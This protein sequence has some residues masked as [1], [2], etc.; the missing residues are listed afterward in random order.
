MKRSDWLKENGNAG[1]SLEVWN[2]FRFF[3][4][5]LFF[6]LGWFLSAQVFAKSMNYDSRIVGLSKTIGNFTFYS[7]FVYLAACIKYIFYEAFQPYIFASFIPMIACTGV[8]LLFVLVWG[9]IRGMNS[10]AKTLHGTARIAVK[11]DLK[12]NGLLPKEPGI[13]LGQLKN[14]KTIA[15]KESDTV[16]R[17]E[18]KKISQFIATSGKVNVLLLAPTGSAK[19]VG[20][21]IPSLLTYKGSV[22][23]FDPKGENY[24][25]TAGWRGTFSRILKFSPTSRFTVRFN[26]VMA[27]RDG[28]EYAFRDANLIAD[29]IFAPA[30]KSGS[31]ETEQYF[32]NSAK[33]MVTT[34]IMH[35]RFADDINDEDRSLSGVLKFLTQTG[36]EDL[37]NN[38]G[39]EEGGNV[40]KQFLAMIK[41]KH[42]YR[43]QNP[44]GTFKKVEAKN[45]HEK[46]TGGATRAIRM[47]PKEKSSTYSTVFSKLQLFDDP[48]IAYATSGNDFEIEDF[49]TSEE[50]ISLYLAIPYS[51]IERIAPI[52]RILITFMLKKFSEGET[53]HGSVRLKHHLNFIL[54]EF[55]VLGHFPIIAQNMGVLRGY[56][57]NFLIVCQALSQLIDVYGKNH[58]FLDHCVVQVV[59]AP[60][61]T[62]DAEE[63]SKAIGNRTFSEMKISSSGKRFGKADNLNFNENASG[64]RFLDAADIKRLPGDKCLILAHGMQPYVATKC[65]YY[66]DP[67]FK[68]KLKL[69]APATN[70]ELS[71][72]IAGLPSYI[73][74]KK[75]KESEKNRPVMEVKGDGSKIDEDEYLIEDDEFDTLLLKLA[76]SS[77]TQ[78]DTDTSSE[79]NVWQAVADEIFE[80]DG[81]DDIEISSFA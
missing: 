65:V 46:I 49:I 81:S 53:Q 25:I 10:R 70:K 38:S 44:D 56:G 47:N 27:I 4:P 2:F 9:V 51:D 57:I 22:I 68:D 54:D 29:I 1:V 73:R 34:A 50:P 26:P 24:N 69:K 66:M 79:N 32:A 43:I 72:E 6:V 67:R 21:I 36:V 15:H 52:I 60:G 78:S 13:I 39:E 64:Q 18:A 31:N 40:D 14:A 20:I 55:P 58:P 3:I 42:F 48:M 30:S 45:L 33:N 8:G 17:L 35:L 5:F 12:K 80:D 75:E 23:V 11:K 74:R 63:F 28:D 77:E 7:I 19:G 41:A 37:E 59:Y 16:L 61:S 71:R 76:A 62:D